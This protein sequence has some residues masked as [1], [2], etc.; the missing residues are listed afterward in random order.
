MAN[1]VGF[2]WISFLAG[3]LAVFVEPAVVVGAVGVVWIWCGGYGFE[4]QG[5]LDL[6][7][8]AYDAVPDF[9]G[10]GGADEDIACCEIEEDVL[11]ELG[12]VEDSV[13]C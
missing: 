2:M 13:A 5:L 6:L 4:E 1:A 9:A 10:L 11:K 8:A 3:W 12:D 7:R